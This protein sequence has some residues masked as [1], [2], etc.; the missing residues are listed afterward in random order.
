M[1]TTKELKNFW[2]NGWNGYNFKEEKYPKSATK[3]VQNK[4]NYGAHK[5]K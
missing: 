4:I 1:Y 5:L 2:H 3:S